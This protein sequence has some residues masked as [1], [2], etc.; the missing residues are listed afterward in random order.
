VENVV[1][2]AQCIGKGIGLH[3]LYMHGAETADLSFHL[4]GICFVGLLSLPICERY[5]F[6]LAGEHFSPF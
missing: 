5:Y 4:I 1:M 3:S 6:E 2:H